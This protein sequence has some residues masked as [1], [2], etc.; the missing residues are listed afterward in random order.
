MNYLL[1][2]LSAYLS[3]HL[4]KSISKNGCKINNRLPHIKIKFLQFSPNIK[5]LLKNKTVHIHH[6]LTYSIILIITLTINV[7]Y[8]ETLFSKGFLVGGII[9]GLSFPDWK[10]FI[11]P[12]SNIN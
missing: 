1:F 2:I 6:W 7:G 10:K 9:Q 12:K 11:I 4:N 8:L 5:I 3:Y